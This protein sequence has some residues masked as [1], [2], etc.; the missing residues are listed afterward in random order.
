L[1]IPKKNTK[2]APTPRVVSPDISALLDVK[3][4]SRSSLSILPRGYSDPSPVLV[5][6]HD[7]TRSGSV[8]TSN[9]LKV[10]H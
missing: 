3:D 7:P 9:H 10:I 1:K 8:I 2:K 4:L 5:I 6:S